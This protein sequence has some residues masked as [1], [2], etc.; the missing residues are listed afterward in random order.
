MILTKGEQM[1]VTPTGYVYELYAPHQ[2]A[3]A[4][5]AR[6]E[7]PDIHFTKSNIIQTSWQSALQKDETME[8]SIPLV[9]G[10]VSIK[11]KE[12][13]LTVTNSH[14]C[15]AVEATVDLL[16]GARIEQGIGQ[17]LTGEIHVHNT[18]DDPRQVIPQAI[19]L[20][21]RLDQLKLTLPPTSI[22]AIRVLLN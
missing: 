16:G 21:C 8:G 9:S 12:L 11:G 18:F 4:L 6:I 2:G 10:S 22:A 7:T 20:T 13:F 3:T 15:E 17:V 5:R 19:D 14:A 1:L